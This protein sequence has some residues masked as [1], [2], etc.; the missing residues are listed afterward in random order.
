MPK[1]NINSDP[2]NKNKFRKIITRDFFNKNTLPRGTKLYIK[3][4]IKQNKIYPDITG[5]RDIHE[6]VK[7]GYFKN[8]KL[9]IE[10]RDKKKNLWRLEQVLTNKKKDGKL[11]EYGFFI[12]YDKKNPPSNW[13]TEYK[14]KI[15]KED[16]LNIEQQEITK[17]NKEN[18]KNK[19]QKNIN[20]RKGK[21]LE[22]EIEMFNLQY[23][24]LNNSWSKYIISYD[25]KK[26]IKS[27]VKSFA[28][29]YLNKSKPKKSI[30]KDIVEDAK[31]F[32]GFTE[33]LQKKYK[34]KIE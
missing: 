29:K 31:S 26:R 28:Y 14:L 34:Q 10:L 1:S 4:R 13:D 2:Y 15:K 8:K 27:Q 33:Y 24:I 19:T 3:E 9:Y 21:W 7:K 12:W 18:Q 25:G 30:C 6:F 32:F 22:K 16:L 11:F 5:V 23:P 20:I 17:S